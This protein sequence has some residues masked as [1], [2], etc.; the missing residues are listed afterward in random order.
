MSRAPSPVTKQQSPARIISIASGKGG[1]GKTSVA[2]SLAWSLSRMGKRVCLL[3]ADLGLSNIDILLNLTP[4]Y[5]LDDVLFHDVSVEKTLIRV[6]KNL[7]VLP[8]S[9]GVQRLAALDKEQQARLISE[10]KK[11][12]VFDYILVDNSPGVI[13]SVISLCL[14]SRDLVILATPDATSITDAYALIKV[15]KEN[16]L[17]WS[18]LVLVNR[19]MSP[20]QAQRVFNRI[21]ET[22]RERLKL[23]CRFLGFLPEDP[24]VGRGSLMRQPVRASEPHCP[25]SLCID[26]VAERL[27]DFVDRRGDSATTSDA[28]LEQSIT[29]FRFSSPVLPDAQPPVWATAADQLLGRLDAAICALDS[30]PP[31][32]DTNNPIALAKQEVLAARTYIESKAETTPPPAQ[33]VPRISKTTRAAAPTPKNALIVCHEHGLRTLLSDLVSNAGLKP[34]PYCPKT[35]IQ[36][37]SH[38][39]VIMCQDRARNPRPPFPLNG[40]PVLWLKGYGEQTPQTR[41][42]PKQDFNV[43]AKPFSVDDFVATV[44]RMAEK[45]AA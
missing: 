12:D 23:N 41:M 34:R 44:K 25:Y 37:Q 43:L 7:C 38:D 29:R 31:L 45:T 8:G 21:H 28:F 24:A 35:P 2:A 22:A 30:L 17:W 36:E 3:D 5:T 42:R 18:P 33:S 15:L 20:A 40:A 27:S 13:P 10:F 9:S 19:A 6:N 1:V 4:K 11:L 39:L 32:P 26:R 16:G 14:S